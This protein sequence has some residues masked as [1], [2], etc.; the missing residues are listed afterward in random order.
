M[1]RLRVEKF[2]FNVFQEN[3]YLVMN[4]KGNALLFDAGMQGIQEEKRF[5][6]Y[7]R[8]NLLNITGYYATHCHL[9]HVFGNKFVYDHFGLRPQCDFKEQQILDSAGDI[10]RMY[11]IQAV[12]I[13]KDSIHI[14]ADTMIQWD[15]TTIKL[16]PTPGH[17]PGS[18]SF[19]FEEE[20][21]LIS[22][23]VLFYDSIGRT[24]LP[25]GNHRQ[26]MDYQYTTFCTSR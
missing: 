15:S 5:N 6:A 10:A 1:S 2:T 14:L 9:D 16:L 19:Y 21:F 18:I 8:S 11:G 17:S 7:F 12:E 22:G 4:E 3:T 26:L 24:D 25:F 13:P 20:G 23:D